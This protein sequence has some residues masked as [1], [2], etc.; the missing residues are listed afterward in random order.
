MPCSPVELAEKNQSVL[1]T[2]QRYRKD[3]TFENFVEF[4]ISLNSFTEFLIAK[5]PNGLLHSARELEQSALNLF[6]D[7]RT[8][9]INDLALQ[10]IHG[11]VHNI[12]R[13]IEQQIVAANHQSERRDSVID[14]TP[15]IYRTRD[16]WLIAQDKEPWRDLL[17]QLGYFGV[18]VDYFT[19]NH[20]PAPM[21]SNP[22]VMI[23]VSGLEQ[24][25]W[26]V[27][28]R[29]LREQFVGSQMICLSM[30]SEFNILQMALQAGCDTCFP[31]DTPLQAIVAHVLELNDPLEH[32]PFRVLVVEDSATAIKLIQRALEEHRIVSKAINDPR[33]VLDELRE[34]QP[35]LILMDMYMPKCTGVEAARVIRQHSQFLSIPIVYLSGETDVALQIDALRLGGDHFLTKPFN[36]V[37]LNA[38]V[39][40]KIERYRSLRRSMYHDS[41]TGLLNHTSIKTALDR[42]LQESEKDSRPVSVVMVDIDYFKK[43]NDTYGHPVGDQVIR[44]L[45]WLLKQRLRKSDLIGRYG[46]EEF[47]VGLVGATPEQALQT[48]DKIRRDFNQIQHPYG[49]SY[50]NIS[51]SAGIASFPDFADREELVMRADEALYRA[52]RGG[53]NQVA[54]AMPAPAE[55]EPQT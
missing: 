14:G 6:G 5:G 42:A 24:A 34:F 21:Q 48:M 8:H 13:L 11:R 9:P 31:D 45:A 41:L 12:S 54:Q 16:V 4:A 19:W 23:D 36:P 30:Q 49:D 55:H 10:D 46:G 43:V 50:F 52:K 18:R 40:S 26:A 47:L 44:S 29:S 32:E 7:E 17:S 37:F 2:W 25:S 39:K 35:D 28:I 1:V 22:I 27:Q 33:F 15:E 53:R 3:S 20:L 51:F 38:I